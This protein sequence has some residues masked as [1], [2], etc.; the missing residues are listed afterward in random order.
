M[1]SDDTLKA[2]IVAALHQR[3]A[4]LPDWEELGHLA[5]DVDATAPGTAESVI[6][7]MAL[8]DVSPVVFTP[9][10]GRS[11][12]SLERDSYARAKDWIERHAPSKGVTTLSASRT[13]VPTG[14]D[15][16]TTTLVE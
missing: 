14:H 12:V 13:G 1:A 11:A 4:C 9:G 10:T 3:G 16:T 7:Q 6:R 8:D 5:M 15:V 2:R